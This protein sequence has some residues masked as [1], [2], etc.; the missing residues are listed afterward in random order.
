MKNGKGEVKEYNL[1]ALLYKNDAAQEIHHI[2]TY[3]L[4]FEGEYLNGEKN[5][6][7]R[8]YDAKNNLIYEGEYIN[9]KRIKC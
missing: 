7:G 8:E 5:G 6:K 4:K 9:G 2:D 3:Y 1:C